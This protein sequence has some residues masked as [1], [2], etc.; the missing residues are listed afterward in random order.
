M[1]KS[2]PGLG[3]QLAIFAPGEFESRGSLNFHF[4]KIALQY[5][6]NRESQD[7]FYLFMSMKCAYG[8][9]QCCISPRWLKMIRNRS[10]RQKIAE[11]NTKS[12]I[13]MPKESSHAYILLVWRLKQS[14]NN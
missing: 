3:I 7:V 5:F 8:F 13:R 10:S 6:Q 4:W 11:V 2:Q 14:E 1:D 12:F 9:T